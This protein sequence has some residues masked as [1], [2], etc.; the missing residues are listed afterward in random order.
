MFLSTHDMSW[1]LDAFVEK[2]QAGVTTASNASTD[3]IINT[4]SKQLT[5]WL[6]VPPLPAHGMQQSQGNMANHTHTQQMGL[7]REVWDAHV[8]ASPILSGTAVDK[9]AA[10]PAAAQAG[11]CWPDMKLFK[12]RVNAPPGTVVRPDSPFY[13]CLIPQPVDTRGGYAQ[14]ILLQVRH[15]CTSSATA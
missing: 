9:Q 11:S 15:A 5:E 7:I 6:G 8:H 3:W 4:A 10:Q 2:V 14:H 12:V 13:G 1:R